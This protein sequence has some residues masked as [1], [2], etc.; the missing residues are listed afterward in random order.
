MSLFRAI[1]TDRSLLYK[2]VLLSCAP[3]ALLVCLAAVGLGPVLEQSIVAEAKAKIEALTNLTRLSISNSL[4]V[5]NKDLLDNFI[6]SLVREP[7]IRYVVM[8][9]ESDG[10]ITSHSDHAFDGRIFDPARHRRDPAGRGRTAAGPKKTGLFSVPIVIDGREYGRLEV[11]YS[12]DR[13]FEQISDLW[14]LIFLLA[15]VAVCLSALL[16]I[17]LSRIIGRPILAMAK[18]AGRMGSGEFSQSINYRSRDALGQLVDSFNR[19]A[20]DLRDR[21]RQLET[22]NTITD[23]LYRSLDLLT[24]IDRTLEAMVRYSGSPQVAVF[25]VNKQ[26]TRLELMGS[27]NLGREILDLIAALPLDRSLSGAA[28]KQGQVLVSRDVSADDRLE[29]AIRQALA[30][31][32]IS[33]IVSVP[34]SFEK[35]IMGCISLAY[36]QPPSITDYDRATLLSIGKSVGLTLTNARYVNRI[37]TE[38]RMRRQAEAERKASEE[39]YRSM[40]EAIVNPVYICSPDYR[41]EYMNPAMIQRTGGDAVGEP[42]Y[43]VIHDREEKCSWCIYNQNS[44][45]QAFYF[46]IIS[47]RDGRLYHVSNSPIPRED[48]SVSK[49]TIFQDITDQR[50]IEDERER[51]EAQLHQAQKMEALGALAGGIA[52]DFNNLLAAIIGF[53]ELALEDATEGA[54]SPRQLDPILKAANRAKELVTQIL[55]F[56]RKMEP[57]LKPVNLNTVIVETEKMLE[58]TIPRMID[59]DFRPDEDLWL[60]NADPSQMAQVLMN[61]GGNAGD[62]MPEGGRLVIQTENITLTELDDRPTGV[63]PGDYVLLTVSDTGHGIP[64]EAL[65]HIFDPFFTQKE[66]GRGTGLGL[67]MVYGIVKNHDGYVIC[68]SEPGRGAAFKVFLPAHHPPVSLADAGEAE[69]ER[70]AD[71]AIGG[72]ETILLV[73]DEENLR[74]LGKQILSRRG[75]RVLTAETGEAAIDAYRADPSGIDL[76]ILDLSMPG[77][78]G[79]KCLRELLRINPQVKVIISSGY[80]EKDPNQD[81]TVDGAT[82]FVP[83]P[84]SMTVMLKAVREALKA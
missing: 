69:P 41:I 78:G 73:D 18:Q 43:R 36:T 23:K 6:D 48:G 13:V 65:P 25:I 39:K 28:V 26:G 30:A 55:T 7:N 17:G 61:L 47:P 34:I 79:R 35:T 1:F 27:R 16:S 58:R 76:V 57:E 66:V 54:C 82:A 3:A 60:I 14:K 77:M 46:E 70:R 74:E 50:R 53:T 80:L 2:F 8:I 67:S 75:Y 37:E 31:E 68:A 71:K 40:M 84:F 51:L 63:M 42:C 4:A 83:K 22:V 21:Q 64:R 19:M 5:Y 32:G 24:V 49:L 59:I 45:R 15:L 38:V 20:L 52:H 56:S 44:I 9:D 33:S 29:P 11:G 81:G 62:A 12:L 72:R 10:R